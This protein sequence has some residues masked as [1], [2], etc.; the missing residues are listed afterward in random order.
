[1]PNSESEIV[2]SE[3]A[4]PANLPVAPEPVV[5]A[6]EIETKQLDLGNKERAVET[7]RETIAE[8]IKTLEE[9]RTARESRKAEREALLKELA[10][11]NREERPA[12]TPEKISAT[13]DPKELKELKSLKSKEKKIAFLENKKQEKIKEIPEIKLDIQHIRETLNS[14][15]LSEEMKITTKKSLEVLESYPLGHYEKLLTAYKNRTTKAESSRKQEA[16]CQSIVDQINS[17]SAR[18]DALI[19][20]LK[21]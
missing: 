6:P 21:K 10:N 19:A 16:R 14:E 7:L 8:I 13:L 17:V 5:I 9:N 2:K 20:D 1:L 11:L 3:P 12:S 4:P 18:Y 15:S